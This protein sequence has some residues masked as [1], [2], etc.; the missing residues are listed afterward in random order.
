MVSVTI[1]GCSTLVV[2]AAPSQDTPFLGM[3]GTVDRL[4][5]SLEVP[6]LVVRNLPAL[7]VW[8]RGE[9]PLKVMVGVDRSL[10]FEAARDVLRFYRDLVTELV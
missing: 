10:P 6:L 2:A 1:R 3:G 9:R 5:Q 4:A 7:E 8:G